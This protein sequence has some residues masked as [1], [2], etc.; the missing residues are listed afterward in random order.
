MAETV[1]KI[2]GRAP[3]LTQ[4]VQRHGPR[5]IHAHFGPDGVRVLP[6]RRA[7]QLPLVVTFHGFDATL[8]DDADGTFGFR[9]FV[10]RRTLLAAEAS[11]VIAVSEFIAGRLR[12]LGFPPE[13]VVVHHI[14][15]DTAVFRPL[16]AQVHP[17]RVLFVGR[18]L[19]KKGVLLLLDAMHVVRRTVP[20]AELVIVGDGPLRSRI[21]L[22]AG[23][24]RRVLITG[25]QTP[26][27]VR[28]WMTSATVLAVPSIVAANG[29]AEG[30]P[31]VVL[32]AA[33]MGLPVAAFS[34]AGIPEAVLQ[35]RTGLLSPERDVAGLA[36]DLA[37]LLGDQALRARMSGLARAHV[38]ANF[39]LRRQTARL[40]ALYSQ[41]VLGRLD[42]PRTPD[43]GEV[44]T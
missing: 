4:R 29:D 26:E 38:Q 20:D 30:L 43:R 5:L 40:E 21:E 15:V 39:E 22:E 36:A 9:Q 35:G 17:R 33:A 10:R 24:N 37:R 44:G 7:L 6:L 42:S 41:V 14:G 16:S 8:D 31:T 2:T 28:E 18:L 32:E 25:R 3:F 11:L 19:E 23:R 12:G 27:Q 13:K 34:S 1:F